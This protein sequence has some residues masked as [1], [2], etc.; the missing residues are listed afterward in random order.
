MKKNYALCSFMLYSKFLAVFLILFFG[1]LSAQTAPTDDYDG[2]GVV[3][4]T[5]LDDDNDGIPDAL[6]QG[7]GVFNTVLNPTFDVNVNNWTLAAGWS[8]YAN[9]LTGRTDAVSS[10][11]SASQSNVVLKN[12]CTS[13]PIYQLKIKTDNYVASLGAINTESMEM[14]AYLGGVRLFGVSNPA[15]SNNP[16]ITRDPAANGIIT[17]FRVNGVLLAASSPRQITLSTYYNLQIVF[18]AANLPA[19]GKIEFRYTSTGDD[20]FIDDVYYYISTCL[21]TDGD[22]LADKFDLDSDGDGCPDAIEGGADFATPH[23][24]NSSIPGGNS[25]TS[26]NGTSTAPITQNLGNTVGATSGTMGIPT[27]AGTGQSVDISTNVNSN[28][29]TDF[30]GDGISNSIDIDDDNDGILDTVEQ[31]CIDTGLPLYKDYRPGT[32]G[33]VKD[34]NSGVNYLASAGTYVQGYQDNGTESF[35]F[36]LTDLNPGIVNT[37]KYHFYSLNPQNPDANSVTLAVNGVTLHSFATVANQ[38]NPPSS[39]IDHGY[40]TLSF[41]PVGTTATVKITWS[42]PVNGLAGSDAQFR[43][44]QING[45]TKIECTNIDTDNDGITNELDL[46]SDGD[47]C[48]DAVEAG[49]ASHAG[50]N[51]MT[52]GTLVNISGIQTGV[53]NAIVGNNTP[54]NYGAN[55]FYN[56]SESNDTANATYT[57]VY[58]YASAINAAIASCTLFC[59]KPAVTS[60]TALETQSGMTSLA[61]AGIEKANWP[62]ARKGG[63]VALE[64]KTK[65]FVPNRLTAQQITDIPAADLKDGMMVYNTDLHCIYINTDGTTTGWKCFNT[66]ACP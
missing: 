45:E 56:G 65:G 25:G 66:R 63:W 52:S 8:N 54:A 32:W 23:L 29:C 30:D 11:V 35:T 27:I 28:K 44:F 62:M 48:P 2:D 18:N 9:A 31:S 19:T 41:T 43:E 13:S 5:D 58:T 24:V 42:T 55:G 47:G 53:A 21:D 51:N 40:K 20:I 50:A 7:T 37:L 4:Q 61:R 46:D 3:N 22:G 36:T 1:N 39:S 15:N 60:G 14:G 6:E 59:Y 26:Y 12:S 16:T 34:A 38:T 57:G 64:A 10:A 33:G 49:S 17:E